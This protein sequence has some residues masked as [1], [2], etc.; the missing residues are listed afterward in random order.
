MAF[1]D[2][3]EEWAV[4]AGEGQ[5]P[6]GAVRGVKGGRVSAYIENFGEVPLGPEH[7]RAAHD[8]KVVLALDALP[9]E[10]RRAVEHAHDAE[11]PDEVVNPNG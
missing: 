7:V 1:E 3:R 10:V 9:D 2:I 8:G 6:L 5:P 4:V 11:Q